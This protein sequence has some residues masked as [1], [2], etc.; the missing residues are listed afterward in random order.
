[1]Q[2]YAFKVQI[3]SDSC[4]ALSN[5]TSVNFTTFDEA[6]TSLRRRL[7]HAHGEKFFSSATSPATETIAARNVPVLKLDVPA[8]PASSEVEGLSNFFVQNKVV[9]VLTGAGISTPSGIPDYRGPS[10]SYKLG[11]KPMVHSE[12]MTKEA[13]RKRFWARSMIG[14]QA[15][16]SASPNAAHTALAQLEHRSKVHAIITQNVDRLHHR[17]GSQSIIDL[18]GRVDQV[19]CQCCQKAIPRH[20][21][22]EKLLAANGHFLQE[23]ET[24][25]RNMRSRMATATAVDRSKGVRAD[26]DA[27]LG[28]EDYSK[29]YTHAVPFEPSLFLLTYSK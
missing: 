20:A 27:E 8:K 17:A 28:I 23:L 18:H 9:T 12:F 29:V 11:H 21:W 5:E 14:W 22:Q 2:R 16:S 1:M 10:G 19:R 7:I 26:G 4:L 13:S 15:V 3:K 6:M 25:Q 24:I